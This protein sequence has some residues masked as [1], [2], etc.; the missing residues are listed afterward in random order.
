MVNNS[1]KRILFIT[2]SLARGGMETVLVNISN[3]LIKHGYDVTLLCYTPKKDLVADLDKCVKYIYKP[4]RE[5]K[6][7]NRI[8]HIRR[9]Y[10]YRKEAWEHRSSARALYR[11]YVGNEKYD[12]E[13][14]FYR[15]PAIKIISGSTNKN[16][17]KFAWVHTDFKLCDQR[18]IVGWC[19][20]F[21]EV[22]KAYGKMDGII[23]VSNQAKESFVEV[24]GHADKALIVYNLIPTEKIFKLSEELCPISKRRFT[25]ITVG[26]LIP[27]KCQDRLLS[28]TKRLGDEGYDFDVWIVGSGR[29]END[30]KDYCNK[31]RLSNVFFT[32][33][34]EN[35]YKYLKQADLFVLTSR[36][37][38]FAI[39]IPEAM[40]CGL[41]V[42][43]T[44][45][46]G[47][48]EILNDGE[49]GIMVSNDEDGVYQ[50]MKSV[51]DNKDC[52]D[53]YRQQ[54][55]KRFHR[56]DEEAII[57]DIIELFD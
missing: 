18:T 11:Y 26:R 28:A 29:S 53:Y 5:F 39:V 23:C 19:N 43:S 48:T 37:E 50:G 38:G 14:G 56:F 17:R 12:I 32:G 13:V 6:L 21:E 42:L 24:I 27:D 31:N 51:L 49:F 22:K 3:A 41:P 45:C 35:P 33:M 44:K 1:N 34:Q 9:Y 52:L 40:A 30:L 15:G 47:P 20:N 36:R 25:F 57:N 16:S 10:N 55:S 2:E 54:S 7:M 8:P 46:T 4:R